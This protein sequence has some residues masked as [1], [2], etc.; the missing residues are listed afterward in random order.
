MSSQR[1]RKGDVAMVDVPYLDA[2]RSV[3]RPAIVLCDPSQML[4]VII[5]AVSSRIRQPRPPAH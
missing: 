4:D 5:A 2:A 1:I 3:R